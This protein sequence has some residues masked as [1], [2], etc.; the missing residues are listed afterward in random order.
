VS[1]KSTALAR[2]RQLSSLGLPGGLFVASLLPALRAL[3]ESESGAFLWLDGEGHIVN[4]YADR[5][6]TLEAIP[7]TFSCAP[8]TMGVC[9]QAALVRNECPAVLASTIVELDG[10]DGFFR[11]I[12]RRNE[13]FHI[14]TGIAIQDRRSIGRLC[15][16]RRQGSRPFGVRE[17][18]DLSSV[19]RYLAHGLVKGETPLEEAW[20]PEDL[21]EQEF[22]IANGEGDV[23]RAS[24]GGKRLLLLATGCAVSPATLQ[25]APLA[26]RRMLQDL[27]GPASVWQETSI[28]QVV[29]DTIWGRFVLRAYRLGEDGKTDELLFGIH[30]KR[31]QPARLRFVNAMGALPLSP[32][33]R[34]I[35]LMIADGRS[36]R[37]IA[38]RLSVSVN[39]VAYHI[40]QLFFKLQ[41]HDRA[42]LLERIAGCERLTTVRAP[43]T[44]PN[45][46]PIQSSGHVQQARSA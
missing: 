43:V 29:R 34:E 3:T 7:P 41:V 32:Q 10:K 36:N 21:S 40:K 44:H 16:F 4:V 13:A 2:V 27:S 9:A 19:L 39:T 20:S 26:M 25:S 23:V 5:F 45:P 14:L 15:L 17:I 11:E 30:M 46:A 8:I 1:K 24:E 37:D 22:V 42:G 18:S 38:S 12:L 31:A 28:R 33:Q 6:P 35:A